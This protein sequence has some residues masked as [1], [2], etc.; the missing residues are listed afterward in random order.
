[1]LP[2]KVARRH[3]IVVV[4]LHVVLGDDELDEGEPGTS[5]E[6]I[7]TAL[8]SKISVSTSRPSPAS[9]AALY[10]R[11]ADEGAHAIVA[12]HLSSEMSGTVESA[13][14][15]AR[16]AP[17]AVLVVDSRAVGP[18]L[19]FAALAAAE[20]V[21]AGANA[22]EAAQRARAR[23][24][25]TTSYFYVDTLEYLRRGGRI[26]A[27]AALLGSALAV[28]PLLTIE[29]GRVVAHER[30]R[31][32]GRALARLE[33]IAL[34]ASDAPR[35]EVVVAHLRNRDRAGELAQGLTERF[36]ERLVG[37]VRV[38]EVGAALAA[39]VGPGMI[40]VCVSPAL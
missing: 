36:G 37:A 33:E 1:M 17:G 7:A 35:V 15:A 28:K 14:L 31:T 5:P 29:G 2:P 4:P 8:T 40:A 10:R 6:E 11:L 34:E 26:G 30:V 23:A 32:S 22:V 20:A 39:H 12:I 13:E 3:G 27:A 18:G 9:L 38:G 16:D 24:E 19:G 21:A 25:A